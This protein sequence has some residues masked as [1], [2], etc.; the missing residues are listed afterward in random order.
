MLR[1][2]VGSIVTVL[3]LGVAAGLGFGTGAYDVAASRSEDVFDRLAAWAKVRS[4]SRQAR[5]LSVPGVEGSAAIAKG[6]DHYAENCLPCH[7]ARGVDGMEFRE[8]M[9]PAPPAMDED[10]V[11]HWSDRELFWIV[12]NGIRMTGMPAFGGNHSDDEIAAIVAFV[13]HAPQLTD[14]EVARLRRA[15]PESHHH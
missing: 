6:L 10:Q 1:I 3:A 11:Q 8:G 12:K 13:R 4:V 5:S 7:G 2:L 9:F 14:G 15:L